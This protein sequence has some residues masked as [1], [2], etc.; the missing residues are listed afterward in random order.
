[1]FIYLRVDHWL[2][3]MWRRRPAEVQ[4]TLPVAIGT[5]HPGAAADFL[6]DAL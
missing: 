3:A 2:T 5:D 6:N 4:A 1:M